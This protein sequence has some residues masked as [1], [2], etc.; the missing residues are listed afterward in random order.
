M[1]E[2]APSHNNKSF[3]NELCGS[4]LFSFLGLKEINKDSLAVFDKAYFK[5]YPYLKNYVRNEFLNAK[6]V[7]EIGLGFG[8]L[9]QHIMGS[10]KTYIG[11]DYSENPVKIVNDRAEM[12]GLSATAKA[13]NGDARDLPFENEK[14]DTVVSIGCLHHTG[15]TRKTIDE[16]YRVLKPGGH[17]II[18]LYNKNSF[19]KKIVNPYKYFVA[20][21]RKKYDNYNEYTRA[22]YDANAKGEAAPI[23]DLYSKKEIKELF[24]RFS[25]IKIKTE[26]FDNYLFV[27]FG[28][29]IYWPREYFLKNLAKIMGLDLYIIATK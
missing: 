14:F 11:L 18:M 2:T 25:K 17:A 4:H 22:S 16:L 3:W 15:D 24:A 8:S 5:M 12:S 21:R 23:V 29:E 20:K 1:A 9:S 10:C 7:L 13:L 27:W 6:D 19:R 28:K 26:N